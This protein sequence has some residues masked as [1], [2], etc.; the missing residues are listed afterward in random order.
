MRFHIV[1]LYLA[2]FSFAFSQES[3]EIAV[4]YFQE[5]NVKTVCL[6][7]GSNHIGK[8]EEFRPEILLERDVAPGIS[9]VTQTS[10]MILNELA[11]I[12]NIN[13]N[14]SICDR[15]V[16]DYKRES[17]NAVTNSL[18][19]KDIDITPTLRF[20]PSHMDYYDVIHQYV[21]YAE[22]KYFYRIPTTGVGKFENQFLTPFTRDVWFSVIGVITLCGLGL[23][24]SAKLENRPK[25]GHYAFFSVVA[26]SCQQF[27]EDIDDSV[28]KKDSTA[29]KL[30]ILVTGIS[31]V[32]IFN[33]YTSSVVSWLLN[34]PPPSINSLW[35]L[36]DSP[37]EPI[38]EDVGYTW[39]WLQLPDYYYNKK[40][41]RAEDV[42]KKRIKKKGNL[43]L[44][45]PTKGVEM[46][47]TGAYAFHCDANSANKYIA[48]TFT[49]KE[50]CDLDSLPSFEKA[51]LYT[52]VQKN[53]PYREFFIWR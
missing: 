53:S 52:S 40:N 8:P 37:L 31:C 43:I 51:L 5:R 30:T 28:V 48:K 6:L 23:L 14:Y 22:G 41:A 13:F 9:I 17:P 49:P 38:F 45:T 18:Y 44:T 35:E 47:R 34:G 21:T 3:V 36:M 10:G 15:W 16:G 33:Y 25:S 26:L 2:K 50:L 19:F 39:S 1:L 12:H 32:L 46:I 11:T 7:S 27:F 42:L 20:L 29:R 4:S 24:L